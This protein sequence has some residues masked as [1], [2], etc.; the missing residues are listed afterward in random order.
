MWKSYVTISVLWALGC[1]IGG[2][3]K[4]E[5]APETPSQEEQTMPVSI[6]IN[7]SWG[8]TP[9][10]ENIALYTLSNTNGLKARIMS[11]GATLVSLEVPD[12]E[13]NMDDIVLGHDAAEGYLNADTNP[14]FGAIVGRYG[15]RIAKGK[16]TL[17]GVEY[18]LATNNNENE[19][20]P[21]IISSDKYK[22]SNI[23][24]TYIL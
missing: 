24:R 21:Y 1:C 2:C 19:F 22:K 13:G 18:T 10:G 20:C 16:F 12:R 14:Y 15:N 3:A 9:E 6:D 8:Q 7:K 11:Y 23:K 4:E 5:P 17:E